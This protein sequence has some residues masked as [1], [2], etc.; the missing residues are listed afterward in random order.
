M[1][2]IIIR[3]KIINKPKQKNYGLNDFFGLNKKNKNL[4]RV[5]GKGLGL[6]L[7]LSDNEEKK[8]LKYEGEYLNGQRHGKGKEYNK[9]GDLIY[10][11]DYLNGKKHGQGKEY[12]DQGSFIT[13]RRML[14]YEGEFK[15][16]LY[17]GKG[18]LYNVGIVSSGIEHQGI[19]EKGKFIEYMNVK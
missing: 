1:I 18:I 12:Y 17:D 13:N 4:T 14:Q 19:F 2:Q 11:G 9:Q 3:L 5:K 15:D 6:S 16:G 10:E 8:I 7:G